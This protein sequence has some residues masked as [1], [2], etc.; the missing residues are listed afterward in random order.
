MTELLRKHSFLCTDSFALIDYKEIPKLQSGTRSEHRSCSLGKLGFYTP[1]SQLPIQCTWARYL[2]TPC[3]NVHIW[4]MR[5]MK[6]PTV[7]NHCEDYKNIYNMLM[8]M[9]DT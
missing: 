4:E 8:N 5:L 6:M 1:W 9:F 3:F 7:L 2:A